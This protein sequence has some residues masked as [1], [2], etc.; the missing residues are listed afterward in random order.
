VTTPKVD[1][2]GRVLRRSLYQDVARRIQINQEVLDGLDEYSETQIDLAGRIV[3][4]LV[5]RRTLD[6][7]TACRMTPRGLAAIASLVGQSQTIEEALGR[8][9][10][11]KAEAL[12]CKGPIPAPT[13][14][15]AALTQAT[16]LVGA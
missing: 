12:L 15:H 14:T 8:G 13:Q 16:I 5:M 3:G 6:R 7:E 11:R 1:K 4:L 9:V 10:V 2:E